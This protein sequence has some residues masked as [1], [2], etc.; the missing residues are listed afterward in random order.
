V[1]IFIVVVVCVV[2]VA[3]GVY[4]KRTVEYK[5]R[6]VHPLIQNHT[7]TNLTIVLIVV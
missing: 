4:L 1:T 6:Y 2:G 3:I 5:L 7:F